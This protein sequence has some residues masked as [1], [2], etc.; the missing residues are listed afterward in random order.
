MLAIVKIDAPISKFIF[1]S[2]GHISPKKQK[3]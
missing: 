1:L 3:I 2:Q